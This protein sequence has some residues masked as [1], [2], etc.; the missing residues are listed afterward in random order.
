MKE[1]TIQ[2]VAAKGRRAARIAIGYRSRE[3][4]QPHIVEAPFRFAITAEQRGRIRW[5]LENYLQYPWGEFKA[6]A[7]EAESLLDEL[8]GKLFSAVFGTRP[9]QALYS[10]ISEDLSSTRIVI[11]A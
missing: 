6:R 2:H 4:A 11:R 10:R 7:S 1:L 5:Y 8:G 9:A 3:G